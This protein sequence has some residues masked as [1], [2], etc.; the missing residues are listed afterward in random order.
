MRQRDKEGRNDE[1]VAIPVL[2]GPAVAGRLQAFPRRACIIAKPKNLR[3]PFLVRFELLLQLP[4]GSADIVMAIQ[5]RK[6][7]L[8][9][10]GLTELGKRRKS[11]VL[12]LPARSAICRRNGRTQQWT[13]R[14]IIMS[15][16]PTS[17][18]RFA[19]LETI[20]ISH[21]ILPCQLC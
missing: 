7:R 15:L 21:H 5:A 18:R 16:L 12:V 17:T 9:F 11:R 8:F 1:G 20:K 6:K 2:L 14:Y 3:T 19:L 13:Y 10:D 4:I